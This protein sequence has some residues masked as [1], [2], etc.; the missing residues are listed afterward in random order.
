MQKCH[1]TEYADRDKFGAIYWLFSCEAVA[2][3]A[4]EKHVGGM[5]KAPGK[6]LQRGLFHGGFQGMDESFLRELDGH[7]GTLA[8]AFHA[9]NPGLDSETL[10]EATQRVLDRLVFMRFLEDKLIELEPMVARFG[11]KGAAWAGFL[12]ASRRLDTISTATFSSRN[13]KRPGLWRTNDYARSSSRGGLWL[14]HR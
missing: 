4:L 6:F 10:T 9:A 7:R 3:G 12:L 2:A 5:P 13:R 14:P 8:R 1:Y 11:D